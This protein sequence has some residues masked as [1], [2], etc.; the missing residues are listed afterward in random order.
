[1]SNLEPKPWHC[2]LD[3]QDTDFGG[4]PAGG[5]LPIKI[6]TNELRYAMLEKCT[7]LS[8][9]NL[10]S[11]IPWEE[12]ANVPAVAESAAAGAESTAEAG[13]GG[14]GEDAE[15]EVW[16]LTK[17]FSVKEL[18]KSKP[19]MCSHG[20]TEKDCQLVAC[21]KWHSKG[22]SSWFSCLDCQVE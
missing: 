2:C 8:N 13:D 6:L 3:C 15:G 14:D 9:P 17:I 11:D 5:E 16:D 21:S 1:M 12:E 7:R 10:P 22:Q 20:E 4:W 18:N 19:K